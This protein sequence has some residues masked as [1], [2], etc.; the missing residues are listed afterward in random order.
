MVSLIIY[1]IIAICM[2]KIFEKAGLEGWKA[3]IPFYNIYV[4]IVYV[5]KKEW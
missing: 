3:I 2:W 4:E 5:A 1:I